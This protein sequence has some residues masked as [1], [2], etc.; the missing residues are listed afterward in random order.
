MTHKNLTEQVEKAKGILKKH[1]QAFDELISNKRKSISRI[2]YEES[3]NELEEVQS[4]FTVLAE[5]NRRLKEDNKKMNTW[6]TD[7]R[8]GGGHKTTEGCP[9]EY[10]EYMRSLED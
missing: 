7:R 6:I 9:C 4:T 8:I 3:R 1:I 10:C 5:E 2:I